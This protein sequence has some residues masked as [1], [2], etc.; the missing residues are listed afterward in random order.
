MVSHYLN[1]IPCKNYNYTFVFVKVIPKTLL[2]PFFSGH[3][4]HVEKCTDIAVRSLTCHTATGTRVPYRI[5]QCYLPS[6][7]GDIPAFT[8]G[9]AGTR[10]RYNPKHKMRAIT[11]HVAWS[12]CLF[13]CLSVCLCS[14][15]FICLLYSVISAAHFV[16]LQSALRSSLSLVMFCVLL[17]NPCVSA[18]NQG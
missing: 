14:F 17:K 16:T 2:V 18:G 9:E 6:D 15:S 12:V 4:V 8:P 13:I 7:R 11:T 3:G 1:D 10:S 5:A